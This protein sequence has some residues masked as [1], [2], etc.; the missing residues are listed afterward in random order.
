MFELHWNFLK[1]KQADNEA[2][3]W[4]KFGCYS[5]VKLYENSEVVFLF[6]I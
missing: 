5:K 3:K 2:N 4:V 1:E 6:Q